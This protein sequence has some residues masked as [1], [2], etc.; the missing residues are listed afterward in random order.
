MQ[1]TSYTNWELL[2][3]DNGSQKPET[4]AYL[5]QIGTNPR[6]RVLRD[7]GS[8]NYARLNNRA[9]GET[10]APLLL[11]LNDDVEPINEGWLNELVRHALRDG[12]AGVG[13][14]LVYPNETLQ[15]AGVII[16][17]G[18]VA[19]HFEKHLP[20]KSAGY[21]R[22]AQLVQNFQAVTAACML[23][24]RTV[25]DAVGGFDAEH[26]R[27]NF[28]DVDLC[29]RIRRAGHRLV[30]TPYA[31]L[32]HHE[33]ATR[34]KDFT[35]LQAAEH[36]REAQLM[37]TRWN[38]NRFADPAYNPNLSL[39]IETPVLATPPRVRKPWL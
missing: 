35:P 30:W 1:R 21:H 18:G 29:L 10:N 11:F 37:Q 16:G 12:V 33:S 17:P 32:Y 39:D 36:A 24:R 5:E 9:A 20:A 28:N 13:A 27:V 14:K 15:H 7:D 22:R 26:L 3:V 31:R 8:F 2:I 23:L 34:G 4:L 25:F 19:G 6:V 38:T